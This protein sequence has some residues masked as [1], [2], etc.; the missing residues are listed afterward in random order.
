MDVCAYDVC[1]VCS[2]GE[3]S[4]SLCYCLAAMCAMFARVVAYRFQQLQNERRALLAALR[5]TR[6]FFHAPFQ[7]VILGM[8]MAQR[9]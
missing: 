6:R 3:R 5:Y 8:G 9:L 1:S 4:I 2:A 7:T